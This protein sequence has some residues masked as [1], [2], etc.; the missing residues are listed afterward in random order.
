MYQNQG[1]YNTDNKKGVVLLLAGGGGIHHLDVHP[2]YNQHNQIH[3]S[4]LS[5]KLMCKARNFRGVCLF[6][7]TSPFNCLRGVFQG[8]VDPY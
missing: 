4:V 7:L 2:L 8:C 5:C 6:T 1:G 3:K